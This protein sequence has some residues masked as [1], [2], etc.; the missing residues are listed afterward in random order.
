VRESLPLHS[1]VRHARQPRQLGG[2]GAREVV[3]VQ[4]P[5]NPPARSAPTIVQHDTQ[6]GV[7]QE[8]YKSVRLVNIPT[9]VGMVPV[10][11]LLNRYLKNPLPGQY[12]PSF[13]ATRRV[14]GGKNVQVFQARHQPH[15]RRDGAREVVVVQVP[16]KKTPP[17]RSVSTIAQRD[18][19]GGGWQERT[20][21]SG[22]LTDQR[23]LGWC[24]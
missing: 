4:V 7:W 24:P 22:W 19:Q 2:H 6:G 5:E 16:E 12:P 21:L 23:S 18:T 10:R 14:E 13:N 9:V 3:V 20:R 15:G 17:A 11:S 1:Q 8:A